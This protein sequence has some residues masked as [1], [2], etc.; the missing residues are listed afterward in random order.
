[1]P[2]PKP[3][4]FTP[5]GSQPPVRMQSHPSHGNGENWPGLMYVAGDWRGTCSALFCMAKWTA[6]ARRPEKKGGEDLYHHPGGDVILWPGSGPFPVYRMKYNKQ[7][8]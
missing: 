8:T 7:G 1:M 6:H 3:F 2:R 5:A 4:F